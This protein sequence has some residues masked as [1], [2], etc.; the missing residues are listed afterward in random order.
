[1]WEVCFQGHCDWGGRGIQLI[2]INYLIA[3]ICIKISSHI[4]VTI[5]YMNEQTVPQ[6]SYI[7]MWLHLKGKIFN[8]DPCLSKTVHGLYCFQISSLYGAKRNSITVLLGFWVA[9]KTYVMLTSE[10]GVLPREWGSVLPSLGWAEMPAHVPVSACESPVRFLLEWKRK[11]W[12][13]CSISFHWANI[14]RAAQRA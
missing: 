10:V 5:S 3:F 7:E 9:Q 11:R 12:S 4:L 14:T 8:G 13:Q 1:M 2:H 6:W